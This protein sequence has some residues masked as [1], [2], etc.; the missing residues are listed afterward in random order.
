MTRTAELELPARDGYALAATVYR[1]PRETGRVAV[2]N[3]AIATPR[4][5]YRHFAAALAEAGYTVLVWDYRGIGGSRRGKLR[6]FQAGMREWIELDMAGALDWARA[7][8][9]PERLFLVGHSLGG[10]VAGL[11]DN[12]AG[13]A[14]MLTLASQSGYWALQGGEQKLML[15]IHAHVVMPTVAR[16]MGYLPW[17]GLK[18]GIP[19]AAALDFASWCRRKGYV[20][21]DPRLPVAN[22]DAFAAPVLAYSFADDKWGTPKAVDAMMSAYPNLERRHVV[23]AEVGLGAIGHF[24]FFKPAA[25]PL[26]GEAIAW[27]DAR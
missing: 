16:V 4:W 22:Y 3:C 24:G 27:L 11:L 8:L 19:K 25:A 9:A 14:G 26:W 23:P 10:Q 5:F 7:E 21:G 20:L 1:P 18:A 12:T 13:L 17:G 2:I 15:L 6:G